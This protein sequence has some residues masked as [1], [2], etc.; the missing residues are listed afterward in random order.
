MSALAPAAAVTGSTTEKLVS[1]IIP[2][3]QGERFIVGAVRSALNQTHRTLEVWVVDDGS[4]DKTLERL[5]TIDDPRLHVLRQANAGT[6]AARNAAIA[7]AQGEYFA[8]LDSDDRWFP[9]KIATELAILQAAPEPIGIAYSAHYAV[10]EQG[11]LLHEAP[12]RRH[13][14]NAYDLMLDG[15]DFLMPSLCLF[16]RRIFDAVGLFNAQCFH[17]DYDFIIRATRHFPIYPTGSRLAV[18][19][20]TTGGKCRSILH[21]YERAREEELALVRELAPAFTPDEAARLRNNTLRSLYL[22]FLMYDFQ[23]NAKRLAPEVD[24]TGLH[25]STKGRLGLLF[26]KTGINLIA[27][28]RRGVQA[29]HRRTR[30]GWWRRHLAAS[31]LE[32]RYE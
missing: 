14:G 25:G 11:R 26:A 7:Q 18:Y 12:V 10:D 28:A 21:D 19:R 8:F 15:E 23:E 31:R 24:F 16:D 6:A 17:E 27:P 9:Q 29:F 2:V 30:Q 4:T 22:R 1:V 3:Y 5:A 32:L 20:Q 13:V